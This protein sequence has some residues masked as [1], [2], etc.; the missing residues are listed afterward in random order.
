MASRLRTSEAAL[1]QAADDLRGY[2]LG[3]EANTGKV[4]P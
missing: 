2:R 1:R 4:V 3:L